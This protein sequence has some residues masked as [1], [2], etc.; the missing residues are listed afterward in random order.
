MFGITHG[1]H[2]GG[3]IKSQRACCLG[4]PRCFRGRMVAPCGLSIQYWPYWVRPSLYSR[5]H[6]ALPLRSAF[7]LPLRAMPFAPLR[8]HLVQDHKANGLPALRMCGAPGFFQKSTMASQ[9]RSISGPWHWRSAQVP[10]P[11]RHL[12][13]KIR[14]LQVHALG[15]QRHVVLISA[16]GLG[17]WRSFWDS[18]HLTR[19]DRGIDCRLDCAPQSRPFRLRVA[20]EDAIIKRPPGMN[21]TLALHNAVDPRTF[22]APFGFQCGQAPR[23]LSTR[24]ILES[25]SSYWLPDSSGNTSCGCSLSSP[26]CSVHSVLTSI[27]RR[28]VCQRR[29]SLSTAMV[30][31]S[32]PFPR[33]GGDSPLRLGIPALAICCAFGAA[34]LESVGRKYWKPIAALIALDGLI[35]SGAPYPISTASA[36]I[37]SFYDQIKS[38]PSSAM[39]LDLPTDAGGTMKTSRYLYLQTAHHKSIPYAPDAQASTSSL[40]RYTAFQE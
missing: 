17:S 13:F 27:G 40:L 5:Q 32:N 36:D 25:L 31:S 22:I 4:T 16:S 1:D 8:A 7:T 21:E 3:P 20:A 39:V 28:L 34:S 37:P 30:L 14:P 12:T 24:F 11:I 35:I 33:F 38:D 23:A 26:R 9:R 2:G 6:W 15:F 10:L 19:L 18:S 29:R